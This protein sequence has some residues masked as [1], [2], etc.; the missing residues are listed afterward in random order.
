MVELKCLEADE[1]AL[2]ELVHWIVT[3]GETESGR[4]CLGKVR[5]SGCASTEEERPSASACVSA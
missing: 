4:S 5:W 3:S 2:K 1:K